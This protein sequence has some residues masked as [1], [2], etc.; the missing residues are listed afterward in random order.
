M[1]RTTHE[2]NLLSPRFSGA[3]ATTYRGRRA[4]KEGYSEQG[5]D[6][7]ELV[8]AHLVGG[9]IRVLIYQ[10][11]EMFVQRCHAVRAEKRVAAS[12]VILAVLDCLAVKKGEAE[13]AA[14]VWDAR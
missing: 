14:A 11:A 6:T 5:T 12:I 1:S 13:G 2:R 4:P 8:R 10:A 3:N 9:R 7:V